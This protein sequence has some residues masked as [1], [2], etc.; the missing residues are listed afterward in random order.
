MDPHS[1]L[2]YHPVLTRK[3]DQRNLPNKSRS[4]KFKRLFFESALV[5][6]VF[7]PDQEL[8]ALISILILVGQ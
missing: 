2:E 5:S 8:P 1:V 7:G 3:K 4:P 6:E